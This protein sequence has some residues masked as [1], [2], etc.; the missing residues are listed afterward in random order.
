M[1][2]L[3]IPVGHRGVRH[4]LQ[5]QDGPLRS[6][7]GAQVRVGIGAARGDRAGRDLGGAAE[8]VDGYRREQPAQQEPPP[9]VADRIRGRLAAQC[10]LH[11]AG[12]PR[13][14][15]TSVW[16]W[17]PAIPRTRAISP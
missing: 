17:K 3:H 5:G 11:A 7:V 15:T 10:L 2:Q 9:L 12:Q 4:R 13:A 6:Q 8:R 14:R 1:R 16:L